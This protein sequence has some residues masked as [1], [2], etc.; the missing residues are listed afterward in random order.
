MAYVIWHHAKV[1]HIPPG[2]GAFLNLHEGMI[3]KLTQDSLDRAYFNH[4]CD[5]FKINN[6]LVYQI[7]SKI[8]VGTDAYVY[9]KQSNTTQDG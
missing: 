5:T 1:A 6:A 8:F 4:Q 3:A 9:G 7:I 2:Y